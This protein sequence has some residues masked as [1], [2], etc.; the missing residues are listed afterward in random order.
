MKFNTHLGKISR[1]N[2]YVF[3]FAEFLEIAKM[4]EENNRKDAYYIQKQL[5]SASKNVMRQ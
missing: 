3:V 1:Y 5:L 2:L 4:G